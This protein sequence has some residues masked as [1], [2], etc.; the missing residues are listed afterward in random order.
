M[1]TSNHP[2]KVSRNSSIISWRK[3]GM[4]V[5]AIAAKFS[6][7]NQR[8]QQIL[9]RAAESGIDGL[10]GRKVTPLKD[11]SNKTVGRLFVESYLGNGKWNCVCSCGTRKAISGGALRAGT[12]SCGCHSREISS[13]RQK[14]HGRSK[15]TEWVIWMGMKTRCKYNKKWNVGYKNYG[16]RGIKVCRRWMRFENFFAD[17]GPRPSLEHTLERIDNNGNY[18]PSNCRWATRKEQNINRRDSRIVEFRGERMAMSKM[19]E[20]YGHLRVTVAY[21][22]SRGWSI[23][24]ALTVPVGAKRPSR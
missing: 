12:V 23:E 20:K 1:N 3:S 4:S 21:R 15:T 14:T 22:I 17:M 6:V 9:R 8:V 18:E 2:E 19:A 16:G 11:M 10:L 24:D 13:C 5:C 7:S